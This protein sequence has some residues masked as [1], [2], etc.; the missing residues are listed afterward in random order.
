MR[1]WLLTCV[2]TKL[3]TPERCNTSAKAGW[4]LQKGYR[5]QSELLLLAFA[6]DAQKEMEERVRRRIG[7]EAGAQLTV[8][9][10]R[11]LGM[12]IGEAE[13]KRPALAKVAEDDKALLEVIPKIRIV[14]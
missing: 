2:S 13:G 4:H 12:S 11:S 8:R 14:L 10:F 5:C 3:T 1:V 7:N 6:K 9:T